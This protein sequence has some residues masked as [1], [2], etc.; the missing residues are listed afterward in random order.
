MA[1]WDSSIKI[2][3]EEMGWEAVYGL[4]AGIIYGHL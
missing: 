1:R 4:R 3:L 2:D